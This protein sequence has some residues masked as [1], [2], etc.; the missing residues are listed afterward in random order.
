[1]NILLV[2]SP[3][4]NTIYRFFPLGIAYI[5]SALNRAGISYQICDMNATGMSTSQ[6]AS[7]W[8]KVHDNYDVVCVSSM[9]NNFMKTKDIVTTIHKKSPGIPVIV[10][11]K[12]AN[13]DK[14]ILFDSLAPDILVVGDG[15]ETIINILKTIKQ[16]PDEL[17]NIKGIAYRQG[18]SV[19][20]TP[21]APPVSDL[22]SYRI[23]FQSFDMARYISRHSDVSHGFVSTQ[24]VSS[25]GCPYRCAYCNNST[26]YQNKKVVY[27]DL[28]NI[29]SDIEYMKKFGLEHIFFVDDVFTIQKD[30]MISICNLLKDMNIKYSISTR[31]DKLDSDKISVLEETGCHYMMLGIETASKAIA[32]RMDKQLNLDKYQSNITRL[33][34]SNIIISC[35]F[36]IGYLGE[37][38][39]TLKETYDFV[40]KNKLVYNTYFSTAFPG[41][42]LYNQLS[43]RI[44]NKE[45]YLKD[46]CELDM[47]TQYILNMSEISSKLLF[48]IRKKMLVGS[49]L[50][51]L[52]PLPFIPKVVLRI[53]GMI[54]WNI[55]Q[56]NSSKLSWL[57]RIT[58]YSN[59]AL[60][61]PFL[62]KFAQS[63]FKKP[64]YD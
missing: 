14:D 37:N 34:R 18:N 52:P 53:L 55:V 26:E 51:I 61:K 5:A 41:T 64:V 16:S 31:L 17:N 15:E 40:I 54:Y 58:D 47:Q 19:I 21:P 29:E 11:G 56:M 62:K 20:S 25:R 4:F 23:P 22:Y 63:H 59:Q 48:K 24:Y 45:Q 28:K 46:L 36:I 6:F 49:V 50:N 3:F 35:N 57:K 1:M 44:M 7:Y 10:G 12:I 32:E 2:V 8:D 33:S 43:D 27:H 30:R 13:V 42:T 39:Q 60:I 38:E 9:I